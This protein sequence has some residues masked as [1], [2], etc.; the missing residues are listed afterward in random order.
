MMMKGLFVLVALFSALA[1]S[2]EVDPDQAAFTEFV[3][4][5]HRIYTTPAEAAG[6]FTIFK[7]N[8]K[9]IKELNAKEPMAQ[10]GV[11]KYADLTPEEFAHWFK[12]YRPTNSSFAK[13]KLFKEEKGAQAASIDWREKNVVTP[14]KN[15]GQCGSC[16]AFSATE[17]LESDYALRYQ[18]LKELAPQQLVSCDIID[19]GCGGGNPVNAYQYIY[20]TAK[21]E[22]ASAD[23]PYTSGTTGQNGQCTFNAKD[24]LEDLSAAYIVS[25]E[26]SQES[27]ML[28]QI[29]E[30][31]M[32]VCVDATTWQTYQS[33]IVTSSTCGLQ[34]DHAVQAVGY[35]SDKGGYWVVRNSWG[36]D[37]GIDGYIYVQAGTNACNIASEATIVTAAPVPTAED[38]HPIQV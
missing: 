35:S 25:Q 5:Y 3:E 6:R 28:Q 29:Q 18:E 23:Y 8:L 4:K 15:Q 1:S 2:A 7:E 10:F 26:P 34:T 27:Q 24:R 17:Q 11:N 31:P 38:E 16:W 30:S 33:G 37:W 21:G 12:G 32:S 22:E 36:T 9:R 14:I 13:P 20:Q 19:L